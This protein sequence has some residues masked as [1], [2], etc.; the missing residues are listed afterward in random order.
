MPNSPIPAEA[1]IRRRARVAAA[2]GLDDEVVLVPSGLPIPVLGTDASHEFHAHGDHLYLAGLET[3][4][5]VLV[6][7]ASD[8]FT[9]FARVAGEEEKVWMGDT[10]GLDSIGERTGIANV[11][12]IEEFEGWLGERAERPVAVLGHDDLVSRPDG[13][14]LR[15]GGSIDSALGERLRAAVDDAR[16]VKDEWELALMRRACDMAAAGHVAAMR[17]AK[18]GMTERHLAAIIEAEFLLD[19]ARGPAYE[20]IVASRHRAAILHGL[21]TDRV[22][23]DGELVLIDAGACHVAYNSDITRTFPV[24]KRFTPEQ[25]DVYE[26]V[27]AAQIAACEKVRA[28]KEYREIHME[29]CVDLARGLV[30]MGVLTGDPEGLVERDVHAIFFP[31][32]VGHMIGISTHDVGG[33]AE[34]RAPSDRFGL[35]FL[36][37]DLPLDVGHVVTI[38][39]GI[40]FIEALLMDPARREKLSDCV[41]W[42]K[43][44]ALMPVGGIRIEDD[45]HVTPDGPEILTTGAPKT[46]AEIEAIRAEALNA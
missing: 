43:V 7:D 38:E 36:R 46:V 11:R 13:Y 32:G 17:M 3:P 1:L 42:T 24:G 14:G 18:P 25:R 34:G 22:M 10:E 37:A 16:R 35:K 9:L 30:S 4:A 44:D 12:P 26:V 21:P 8:G 40:Y 2:W 29:T 31:H 19:G 20:S 5:Q 33:Y 28:G 27:L 39:P 45:V 6:F 41:D 23:N 15:G